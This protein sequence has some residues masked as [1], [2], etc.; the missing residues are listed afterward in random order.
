MA[1]ITFLIASV[2][3]LAAGIAGVTLMGMGWLAGIALYVGIGTLLPLTVLL[4]AVA[5]SDDTAEAQSAGLATA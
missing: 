2:L 4:V 5:L 1:A 3:G